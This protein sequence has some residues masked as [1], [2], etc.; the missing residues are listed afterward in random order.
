ML[1]ENIEQTS[2]PGL[3]ERESTSEVSSLI[4]LPASPEQVQCLAQQRVLVEVAGLA[5]QAAP[6][7]ARPQV[8]EELGEVRG[9]EQV[10]FQDPQALLILTWTQRLTLYFTSEIMHKR[11]A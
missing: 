11:D 7:A 10:G 8:L 2:Q 9:G 4:F 6:T 3:V 5:G 1:P